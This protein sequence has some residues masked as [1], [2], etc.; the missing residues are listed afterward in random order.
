M[1]YPS[2]VIS[3]L[4]AIVASQALIT[5]T[6]QLLSQVM[7][8]SY[9]PQITKIY[10]SDKFHG[11][12]YIPLANW[13]LMIG[14]VVVTAVYSNTTRLGQAYGVC[15]ILVTFITTCMV[16]LVALVVW[17]L[18]WALVLLAWIPFI[19]L[20]GL[21]MSSALVKVP[22]GAWFTLLLAAILSS[23]FILWRYGKEKQWRAEGDK[24]FGL[25]ELLT[26][27]NG[28]TRL[29]PQAGG[30]ELSTIRGTVVKIRVASDG[31]TDN[32]QGIGIFFDKV[33]DYSPTPFVEFV[34]KFEAQP[35]VCVFLHLRALWLPYVRSLEISAEVSPPNGN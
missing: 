28:T 8:T 35:E 11:Q 21:Y 22:E 6:F 18:H 7:N 1:F 16:A 23:S 27:S 13:L 34:R 15:V 3:I 30:H 20:D 24:R 25:N 2:F 9:F 26:I 19:A 31:T 5:S 14:T 32:D 29:S 4:A 12:V 33:G 17:R 10:T